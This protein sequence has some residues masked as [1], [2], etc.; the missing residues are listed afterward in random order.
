MENNV[1][2]STGVV[3]TDV[4][5]GRLEINVWKVRKAT[6][7]LKDFYK[8]KYMIKKYTFIKTIDLS[9]NFFS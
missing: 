7:H 5:P 3:L 8:T 6:I 1:I 2:T 9:N 4:F